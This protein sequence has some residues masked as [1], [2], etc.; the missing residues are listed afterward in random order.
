[1]KHILTYLVF[2]FCLL[3]CEQKDTHFEEAE[4][5]LKEAENLLSESQTNENFSLDYNFDGVPDETIEYFDHSYLQLIDRNFDGTA[6]E[7][8]EYDINTDFVLDGRLD[9][10]FDGIFETQIVMSQGVVKF[11]FT[12]S[13]NNK[14]IDIV[15]IYENGVLKK[16]YKYIENEESNLKQ[17]TEYLFKYGVPYSEETNVTNLSDREFQ[18]GRAKS[19]R[20][21]YGR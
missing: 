18:F 19:A 10:D 11:S 15:N 4:A 16:L 12:D 8:Y 21:F 20:P 14:L 13:N 17:I 6:D 2:I 1:M 9:D 3:G 7:K 5:I